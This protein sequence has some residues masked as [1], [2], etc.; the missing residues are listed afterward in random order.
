MMELTIGD[1]CT[2]SRGATVVTGQLMGYRI[3]DDGQVRELFIDGFYS[4]FEIGETDL[5]WQVM[6]EETI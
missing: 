2:V 4:A 5:H 6:D 1:F 3:H